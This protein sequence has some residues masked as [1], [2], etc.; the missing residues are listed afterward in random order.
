MTIIFE[1]CV[2]C[3]LYFNGLGVKYSRRPWRT[4][5]NPDFIHTLNLNIAGAARQVKSE[6]YEMLNLS[7]LT[8]IGNV[9]AYTI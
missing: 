8:S 9:H 3:V 7:V 5:I 1:M 2:S 6:G 4:V